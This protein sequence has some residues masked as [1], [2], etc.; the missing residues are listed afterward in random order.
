[1][2]KCPVL[3]KDRQAGGRTELNG[4]SPTDTRQPVD[5][6]F[7]TDFRIVCGKAQ[8]FWRDLLIIQQEQEKMRWV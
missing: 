8:N 1:M 3:K 4:N 7:K 5:P 2:E 6:F